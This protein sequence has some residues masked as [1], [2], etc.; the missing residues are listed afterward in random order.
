MRINPAWIDRWRADWPLVLLD[1]VSLRHAEAWPMLTRCD[2]EY[3]VVCIGQTKRRALRQAASAFRA[4]GVPLLGC[5]A[6]SPAEPETSRELT[7]PGHARVGVESR[8]SEANSPK[9]IGTFRQSRLHRGFLAPGYCPEAV[10]PSPGSRLRAAPATVVPEAQQT[11][12]SDAEQGKGRGLGRAAGPA[13]A[14]E[15][16]TVAAQHDGQVV[17]VRFAVAVEVALPQ[18]MP[19]VLPKLDSTMVRSLTS[20]RPSPLASPGQHCPLRVCHAET[21]LARTRWSS[22][23]GTLAV[24][25]EEFKSLTQ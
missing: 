10:I 12:G 23:Q 15:T 6:M 16:L 25:E 3:L 1:A 2:S 18:T 24:Q 9:S 11:R 13:T 21:E 19:V 4:R 20:T 7:T 5:V 14:A 22:R 17:D 8:Q